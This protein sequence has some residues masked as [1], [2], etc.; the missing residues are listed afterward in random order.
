[1]APRPS[2]DALRLRRLRVMRTSSIVLLCASALPF[3]CAGA[4]SQAQ[5]REFYSG[6]VDKAREDLRRAADRNDESRAL[7]LDELGTIEL[8]QDDLDAAYRDLL[9][10]SNIMGSFE[11]S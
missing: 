11:G 7:Y 4:G 3:G 2:R 8:L 9:E 10:A 6:A 1:M 5:V